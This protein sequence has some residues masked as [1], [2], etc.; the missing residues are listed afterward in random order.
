MRNWIFLNCDLYQYDS[1]HATYSLR[2]FNYIAREDT[3]DIEIQN[4]SLRPER[5]SANIYSF[6]CTL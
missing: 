1:Q 3:S 6:S 2:N 4:V 5:A